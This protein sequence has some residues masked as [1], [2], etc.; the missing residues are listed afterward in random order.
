MVVNAATLCLTPIQKWKM[1]AEWGHELAESMQ[2]RHGLPIGYVCATSAGADK[3][4]LL[5]CDSPSS[6][7]ERTHLKALLQLIE[8][9]GKRLVDATPLPKVYQQIGQALLS[10]DRQQTGI[11]LSLDHLLQQSEQF[12]SVQHETLTAALTFF[13]NIGEVVWSPAPGHSTGHR[14]DWPGDE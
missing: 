8:K 10:L 12:Q 1:T 2:R 14:A 4:W 3:M 6:K 11:G 5:R 9:E 13:H 7:P